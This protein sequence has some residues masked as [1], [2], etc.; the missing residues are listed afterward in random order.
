MTT[1]LCLQLWLWSCGPLGIPVMPPQAHEW[2]GIITSEESE[3]AARQDEDDEEDTDEKEEEDT[4][5][6]EERERDELA[7]K[8]REM[9][10]KSQEAIK[11]LS[12]GKAKLQVDGFVVEYDHPDQI[13]L[14][15]EFP[16]KNCLDNMNVNP[17]G[18]NGKSRDEPWVCFTGHTS[19][20]VLLKPH[21]EGKVEVEVEL[22]YEW[23]D[24]RATFQVVLHSNGKE[25]WGTEYGVHGVKRYKKNPKRKKVTTKRY[26]SE[27]KDHHADPSRW[28]D[29]T[30]YHVV[31]M[32]YDPK[33]EKLTVRNNGRETQSID[34]EGGPSSGQ[35]GFLWEKT[36]FTVMKIKVK[37]KLDVEWVRETVDLDDY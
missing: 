2:D 35:V 28:M 25:F 18:L 33:K 30:R 23:I 15:V 24:R 31:K 22:R 12:A 13:A 11:D 5:T 1:L 9:F 6:P 7:R 36:R 10:R 14:D 4:R 27:N 21:F 19:G 20:H 32:T 26:P 16:G 34:I 8:L 3:P 17:V 29:R 37:G